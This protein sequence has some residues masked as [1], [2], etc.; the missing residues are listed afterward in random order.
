MF[1]F[2]VP[3]MPACRYIE[4]N[5]STAM[6]ATRR[7]VGVTPEA[8]ADPRGE[9]LPARA[10]PPR[11]DQIFLNFMQ[12]F[13]NFDKNYMLAPPLEGWRPLLGKSWIRL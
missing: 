9:A 10:P 12:F 2:P 3:P 7:S 8:V 5:N 6:L 11:T 4:E 13:G 1:Q